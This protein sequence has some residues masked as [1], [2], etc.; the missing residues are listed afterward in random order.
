MNITIF[1]VIIALSIVVIKLAI[2]NNKVKKLHDTRIIQ[3]KEIITLLVQKQKDLN[4]KTHIS[5]NFQNQYHL[6][7]KR[8][9][10]EVF[11]LQKKIFELL[12]NK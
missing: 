7:L 4:Q 1:F 3:L 8:L 2:I 6:D 12:S 9:S 11:L 10:S 5:S